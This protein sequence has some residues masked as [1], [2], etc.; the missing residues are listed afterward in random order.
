MSQRHL[1]NKKIWAQ[2]LINDILNCLQANI[3]QFGVIKPYL[4]LFNL[5]VRDLDFR[6][7]SGKID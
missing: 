4:Q 5:N 1:K 3:T 7:L 2:F 6:R